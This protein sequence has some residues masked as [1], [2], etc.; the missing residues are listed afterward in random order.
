MTKRLITALVIVAT[1]VTSAGSAEQVLFSSFNLQ[2]DVAVGT[3]VNSDYD[4]VTGILTWSQGAS[5]YLMDTSGNTYEDDNIEVVARFTNAVDYSN[6]ETALALFTLDYV[7]V[8]FNSFAFPSLTGAQS[9]AVFQ[10]SPYDSNPY[11]ETEIA[12]DLL[13]GQALVSVSAAFLLEDIWGSQYECIW[14][15]I[16]DVSCLDAMILLPNNTNFQS[17]L[18]NYSSDNN[19][20][21]LFADEGFYQ[22]I[23]EPCTLGLVGLGLVFIRRRLI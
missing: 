14:D 19:T 23:P 7:T 5:G 12:P 9:K 10:I 2:Y 13:H 6:G 8:T 11:G 3:G 1:I 17:Y 4:A 16:N 18:S 15:G 21:A 20:I 22:G